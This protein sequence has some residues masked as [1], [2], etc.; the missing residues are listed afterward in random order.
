MSFKSR[1]FAGVI[2]AAP[3]LWLFR[4]VLL[5]DEALYARDVF[6]QYWPLR[7]H[8]VEAV[9]A[10]HL[11]LWDDASQGGLPLLAN[12]HAAVL[13]PPNFIYQLVSFS[14]GYGWLVAA[15]LVILVW[16]V[17]AFLSASGRGLWGATAAALIFVG[18]APVL[19]LTAFGPHLMGLAWVP[20]FAHA[21]IRSGSFVSRVLQGSLLVTLQ[22]LCGDPMT[23]LLSAIVAAVLLLGAW[24]PRR[25]ALLIGL[26]AA[27]IGVCCAGAQLLP[28]YGL[29]QQTTR[30]AG[31]DQLEWSMHPVR[32]LELV[33]PKLFGSLDGTPAFWGSFLALGEI[34]TPFSLSTY[35]GASAGA[36]ALV[37]LSQKT[38]WFGVT[39]FLVGGVLALGNQFIAG[40]FLGHVPPF[41]LFRYPEKYLVLA[42]LGIAVLVADGVDVLAARRITRGEAVLIAAP[43]S[44]AALVGLTLTIWPQ[45]WQP[46]LSATWQGLPTEVPL[47][48]FQFAT[49]AFVGLALAVGLISFV[50]HARARRWALGLLM[51]GDAW[52]VNQSVVFMTPIELFTERPPTVDAMLNGAS[53]HPFRLWRDNVAMAKIQFMTSTP[54]QRMLQR[55]WELLTL[56]SS[57]STVFGLQELSGN[58]P[59]VLS[60]WDA[61]IR[62]LRGQPGAMLLLYNTCFVIEPVAAGTFVFAP[63]PEGAGVRQIECLPRLFS[64]RQTVS[65]AN[66]SEALAQVSGVSFSVRERAVVEGGPSRTELEPVEISQVE[67]RS[68]AL[69]AHAR[70]GKTGG[71]VVFGTS[72]AKGWGVLVDG[73]AAPLFVVDAAVMGVELAPGEH[74]LEFEFHEPWLLPGSLLS[75]LG[76][77]LIA[78]V[79]VGRRGLN[80]Y[81]ECS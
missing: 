11:P 52:L 12:I 63:M 37:G 46:Y 41:S 10:G 38:R 47:A 77:M 54:E 21:L 24:S 80:Q 69:L 19:G 27:V 50:A 59:V 70:A 40:P 39:L 14:T 53:V 45:W 78:A 51:V 13:Y 9:R 60:R 16:G 44:V 64:V 18:S 28:A 22:C 2:L 56:K 76:C 34:K 71:F 31:G 55:A 8:V 32:F 17:F 43:A 25:P 42:V 49:L 73:Q 33:L 26:T 4:S 1:I 48:S 72:W 81:L 66:Q 30:A 57:L 79:W 6:H 74:Q 61:L 23:V 36:V 75:A 15:H 67:A 62:A 7:T 58:S 29:L 68:G 35:V 3:V 20:W 5:G 65:V